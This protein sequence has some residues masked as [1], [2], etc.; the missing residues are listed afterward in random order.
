MKRLMLISA[1]LGLLLSACLPS[2]SQPQEYPTPVSETDLQATA[3]ILSQ[4]TLQAIPTNTLHPTETPKIVTPSKTITPT[5]PTPTETVNPVLLTLT[6]TLLAG[7][8]PAET[9]TT[10]T[11]TLSTE[12]I[13]ETPSATNTLVTSTSAGGPAFY[14]TLPPN[15]PSGTLGLYNRDHVDV[16]VSF[17]CVT[18]DGYVTILEYPVNKNFNVGAPAGQY[19]YVAWVGGRQFEGS[20]T[21]DNDGY[22]VISFFKNKVT[23]KKS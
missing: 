17:R 22:L 20:F 3:A 12:S 4:Q 10:V 5:Q 7:T 11:E 18:K 23:I 21:L 19:T 15:L 16:Y 2:L 6:A 8:L 13:P 14:G 9:Q 1:L